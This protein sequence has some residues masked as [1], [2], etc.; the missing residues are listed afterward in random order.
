[1]EL[2][3]IKVMTFKYALKSLYWNV[4]KC[5]FKIVSVSTLNQYVTTHCVTEM[6]VEINLLDTLGLIH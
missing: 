2:L 6:T 4:Q 5:Y 1:M 3:D